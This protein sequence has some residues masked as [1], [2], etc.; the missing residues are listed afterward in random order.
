MPA[1]GL[2]FRDGSLEEFLFLIF[3]L[4]CSPS[5]G[6]L[7]NRFKGVFGIFFFA[8]CP[9]EQSEYPPC[10]EGEYTRAGEPRRKNNLDERMIGSGQF[11]IARR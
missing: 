4:S 7:V 10:K 6:P 3:S 2:C 9:T 8:L 1:S 5:F 11:C